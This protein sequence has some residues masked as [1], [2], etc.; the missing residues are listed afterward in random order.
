MIEKKK[1][2]KCKHEQIKISDLGEMDWVIFCVPISSLENVLE[3][4]ALHLKKGCLVMDVCS[5][6][7][8]PCRW[9]EKHC[10]ENVRLLGTHPMFGP[11]SSKQGLSGLQIVLCPIR[12]SRS[13][14][15]QVKKVFQKIGLEIVVTTPREHDKEAAKSLALVHFLGRALNEV[16]LGKQRISTLGFERLLAVNETVTNDTWQLFKDM[17]CYN[18]YAKMMRKK[19]LKGC[20]RI[21]KK[22]GKRR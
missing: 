19:F 17:Q 16:G 9:L 22:I 10:P 14:L 11:D 18:Q 5:V 7:V 1:I 6:K 20:E 21:E 15:L 2:A 8:L 3:K 12:I 4:T 13:K